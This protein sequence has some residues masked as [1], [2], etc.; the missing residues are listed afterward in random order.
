M[1]CKEE[2]SLVWERRTC[3]INS[4]LSSPLICLITSCQKEVGHAFLDRC[5]CSSGSSFVF[6]RKGYKCFHCKGSLSENVR[7]A[8]CLLSPAALYACISVSRALI[9]V[10]MKL[11]YSDNSDE[12]FYSR[13]SSCAS[14]YVT[15][16]TK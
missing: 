5:F 11:R 14:L 9:R 8:A 1:F 3:E 7:G 2:K 4:E 10:E 6:S 15:S 16:K 13:Q 12:R